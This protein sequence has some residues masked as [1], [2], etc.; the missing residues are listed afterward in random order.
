MN[1]G[2]LSPLELRTWVI[3]R[4][5][6]QTSIPMKDAAIISNCPIREVRRQW[7]H[8]ITDHDGSAE[9][10]GGIESWLRLGEAMG[11]SRDEM[12][13]HRSVVPAARFAVEAYVRF[14][15]T[16][17]WPIAVASSLTELF[18]PDHMRDR[19]AKM[20]RFYRW[21][22]SWGYDYFRARFTQAGVDSGEALAITLQY[23]DTPEL[24][25]QAVAALEFKCDVLWCLLDAVQNAANEDS[26]E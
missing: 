3:N 14:A 20:E 5:L 13:D 9:G 21:I 12:L 8:R 7:I 2:R 19:V 4:F 18:A 23:C 24:Q 25:D 10:Q 17:P 6:Y 22:P 1:E 11:I 16:E 26:G 15:R